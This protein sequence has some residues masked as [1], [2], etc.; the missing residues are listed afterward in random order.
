MADQNFLPLLVN[1]PKWIENKKQKIIS[2]GDST[3][4]LLWV[5]EGKIRRIRDGRIYSKNSFLEV[6][7]FFGSDIY[8]SDIVSLTK[9][10]IRVISRPDGMRLFEFDENPK[11]SELFVLLAREK[12]SAEEFLFSQVG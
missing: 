8:T 5:E 6:L 7:S 10:E 1:Q 2:N 3:D 4:R 11:L 12:L 9:T